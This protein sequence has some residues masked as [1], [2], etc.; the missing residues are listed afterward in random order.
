M[1][2][3]HPLQDLA[4]FDLRSVHLPATGRLEPGKRISRN[5]RL[6]QLLEVGGMGK[7]WLAYHAG[8][9]TH[10]AVKFMSEQSASDPAVVARFEREAKLAARIKSPHVVQTLDYA[11]TTDGIPFIVMELLEGQ[12]LAARLESLP[13]LSLE[14]T[15]GVL[16]QIC[17]ALAKAHALGIVHRDIK[18][19]N[20]YVS[21]SDG[22]LFVKV[23]DFGIARDEARP[24]SITS[25]DVTVG[26]PS[27]MSPEQLFRPKEVD[28][29]SD[30][31]S[32]AVLVYH[33]LTG[34]LPFEGDSYASI[35]VTIHGAK[36]L[37][38]STLG[39]NV[40]A[41]LDA[42]F[43]KALRPEPD[44]RFQSASEMADGYLALLD[45]AGLLPCWAVPRRR[46]SDP[47]GYSTDAFRL[48]ETPTLRSRA[49]RGKV[50]VVAATGVALTAGAVLCY[51]SQALAIRPTSLFAPH[52]DPESEIAAP[53][54]EPS[55][56]W[57]PP[58]VATALAEPEHE[59]PRGRR[60]AEKAMVRKA[61]SQ[62]PP[63]LEAPPPA[64]ETSPAPGEASPAS[65][66]TTSAV[67]G[68]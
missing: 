23:L 2:A 59:L 3:V 41:A 11:T 22:E 36:F 55:I 8:L 58:S 47:P 5:I 44:E 17:R 45:K 27:F 15:S 26:T 63:V 61:E 43:E 9:D 39:V 18:P 29:R 32:T 24:A 12:D 4:P 33:C 46:K 40:P 28:H 57:R 14:D 60:V 62:R 54:I 52:L 34:K 1:N 21:E 49:H 7:V 65:S 10:V 30:L 67:E 56:S 6:V 35:C 13:K 25:S 66:A 64:N 48:S 38:P 19:E 68:I 20:I 51:R 37:P 31:W 42:W 50:A 53:V 16:I